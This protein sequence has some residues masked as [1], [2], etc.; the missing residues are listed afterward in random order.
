MDE[1]ADPIAA[2]K[3]LLAMVE[4]TE[5]LLHYRIGNY[6]D[7]NDMLRLVAMKKG[8]VEVEEI[9]VPAD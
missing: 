9:T 3:N 4:K 2:V 6:E 8:L 5:I 7:I 1:I